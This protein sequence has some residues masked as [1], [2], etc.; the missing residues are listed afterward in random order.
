MHTQRIR[1]GIALGAAAIIASA[2]PLMAKQETGPGAGDKA[3]YVFLFVGDGMAMPQV[4][5]AEI[6]KSASAKAGIQVS[7][8]SFTQFP[9]SGLTTTYDASSF[10]T[11]SASAMTA[12]MTG[13]KTLSGVINMD[14]KKT[15]KYKTLAEYAKEGGYRVG[16]V[17]SVSLDHATPAATYAKVASRGQMYDIDVQLAGSNFDYFGGGGLTQKGKK[18]G[19]PDVLELARQ[20]GFTVVNTREAFAALKPGAGKVL[21]MNAILQDESALPYEMDR[22]AG[23]PSLA[24]YTQKG[25]ELLDNP[26]G[27]FMM[28]EGGKID[29]A[30]H[31][32]DASAAIKDTLAFDEA[33]SRAVKFADAHPRE[34]L[35]VVTGDHETGGMTI[36]FSG[37]KYSTFFDK[38]ALQQGSYIAFNDKVLGPYKKSHGK[39]SARLADL[40][41]EVEQ[42]FGLKYQ[43]LND[44]DKELLDRA[45]RRSLGQELDRAVE[46]NVYSLYGD[47]EPFTVALTHVLN[48]SAGI[49]WTSYSHT[50]VPVATFAR[51]VGQDLFAGYYDN[52][53]IFAKLGQ[54]MALTVPAAVAQQ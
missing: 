21:A 44:A 36:G 43:E 2:N 53:A 54:A 39:E 10:I 34:T 20:N 3:R 9:S 7:H 48:Q 6:F 29:W 17:S 13:H 5:A 31:A 25:I 52:T 23:D 30:C 12:M 18:A 42:Y 24:D 51:G 19:D 50:G 37:T 33:V 38:I 16:V 26:Q 15:D 1:L 41:P 14:T 49:G 35:I 27:F 8:L 47:Y 46:E 11:D 40:L 45:F 4:N 22:G 28:V 32:N